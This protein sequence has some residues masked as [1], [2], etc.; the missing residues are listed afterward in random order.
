MG[1]PWTNLVKETF[2]SGKKINAMYSL[3][4]AMIEA[5]KI[6]KPLPSANVLGTKQAFSKKKRRTARRK[7]R[8]SRRS[9]R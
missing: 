7:G 1:N 9:R 8:L 3:K 4:D 6:Y 5:K 2:R